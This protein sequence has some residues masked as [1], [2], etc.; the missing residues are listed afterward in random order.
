MNAWCTAACS[1]VQRCFAKHNEPRCLEECPV[2]V[3]STVMAEGVD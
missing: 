2:M 1:A 3:V